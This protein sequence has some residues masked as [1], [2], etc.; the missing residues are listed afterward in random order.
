MRE[1]IF[2]IYH[3]LMWNF[4]ID[5][6]EQCKLRKADFIKIPQLKYEFLE[7]M[8]NGFRNMPNLTEEDKE[9]A[10]LIEKG[11]NTNIIRGELFGLLRETFTGLL[12]Q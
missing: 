5:E 3:V 8:R 7:N 10:D 9:M 11:I 4:I 2:K 1:E 12:C 6:L